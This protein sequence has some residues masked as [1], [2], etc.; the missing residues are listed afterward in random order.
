MSIQSP[1]SNAR[2]AELEAKLRT[3]HSV[4]DGARKMLDS[5][6]DKN[7][8]DQ[9]ETQI[10]EVS[11]RIDYLDGE[12]ARLLGM[13]PRP[14]LATTTPARLSTSVSSSTSSLYGSEQSSPQQSGTKKFLGAIFSTFGRN[15]DKDKS[16]S[17]L[18]PPPMNVGASATSLVSS[19]VPSRQNSGLISGPGSPS[20]NTGIGAGGIN[21]EGGVGGS[22]G[23]S[24]FG[25]LTKTLPTRPSTPE[26]ANYMFL[27]AWW[28]ISFRL[29]DFGFYF[30]SIPRS[31]AV[32]SLASRLLAGRLSIIICQNLPQTPRNQVQA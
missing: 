25:R 32:G 23:P 20:P 28:S 22:E 7:A 18:P 21:L 17:S 8:R 2:V 13:Q 1:Q 12:R 24:N 10:R 15:K 30:L 3:E 19:G 11:K 27:I 31:V 4:L 14:G 6:T 26:T 16:P 5:L 29:A 9:C